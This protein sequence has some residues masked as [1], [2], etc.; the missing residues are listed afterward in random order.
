L[1][2]VVAIRP[3]RGE[4]VSVTV[5]TSTGRVPHVATMTTVLRYHLEEGRTLSLEDYNR[6]VRDNEFEL[7]Y[8]KAV[9]FIGHRMRTIAEVKKKLGTWTND[10][11]VIGGVVAE[12]KRHRYLGD[13][14]YVKEYVTEKMNFDLVGPRSIKDKLV[15]K[16]IH[17]DL[18]DGELIRFTDEI[19]RH[20]IEDLL[21]KEL[22]HPPKQPYR[23]FVD[24]FTRKCVNKGFELAIVQHM[25]ANFRERIES[26][27][28]EESLLIKELERLPKDDGTY[29]SRQRQKQSLQRKGFSYSI[30]Q[31]HFD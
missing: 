19:Q 25:I 30:I 7:L 24:S 28:D 21:D 20:K 29:E 16:G 27:I 15:Q 10:E 3:L 11:D 6:F 14:D 12:L 8:Q 23:K 26:S 13:A 2:K 1:I 17:Y 22:R 4:E 31:K 5:E 9:R 18:I